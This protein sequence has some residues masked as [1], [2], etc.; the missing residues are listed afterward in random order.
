LIRPPETSVYPGDANITAAHFYSYMSDEVYFSL[1]WWLD[2]TSTTNLT[3]YGPMQEYDCYEYSPD[4]ECNMTT[5]VFTVHALNYSASASTT[6]DI[7]TKYVAWLVTVGSGSHWEFGSELFRRGAGD[8]CCGEQ[9]VSERAG[10][11][12]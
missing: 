12:E 8:V 4:G 11:R 5:G 10:P 7:D 6:A 2:A 9:A 1:G 3:R